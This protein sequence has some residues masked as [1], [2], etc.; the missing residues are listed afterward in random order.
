MLRDPDW[1][2]ILTT[3][4]ADLSQDLSRA[5]RRCFV[6]A[7]PEYGLSLADDLGRQDAWGIQ[8]HK[9]ALYAIGLGGTITGRGANVLL[10]DDY[11]KNREEAESEGQRDKVWDSFRSDLMTRLAPVHAVVI[12]ATRWHEDDLVGRIKTERAKDPAFPRF[13][14]LT[15]PAQAEDGSWLFPERFPEKWYLAQRAAVGTY[16]WE[17]LYQC[18]PKPRTGNLFRVDLVR[19]VSAA[20][21]GLRWTRGWDLASTEKQRVRDDPDSTV[22]VRT[23]MQGRT[24][25]VDDV[26]RGQWSELKRDQEIINTARDDGPSVP[27]R[28][29]AVA[30]YTDTFR[31]IK[32]LLAGRATVRACHPQTDKFSRATMLE[33]LFESGNVVLIAGPWNAAWLAE[34][35]AFPKAKHDDQ[36]DAT[37]IAS[38]EHV[39]VRGNAALWIP[40]AA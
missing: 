31:R 3:Y 36:V 40:G 6:E 33:P 28:V 2:F 10:I 9:G 24:L 25:Y 22:G 35:G 32:R 23:A 8:G 1:E 34:F 39:R 4:G 20:P 26:R 15:F 21:P 14:F 11:C 27:V 29:E 16:A 7:A 19:I 38:E 17:S 12:L 18:N 13:E 5:A 37:V 30:G